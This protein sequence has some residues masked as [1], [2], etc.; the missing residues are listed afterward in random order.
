M[1]KRI[2]SSVINV[3][4]DQEAQILASRPKVRGDMRDP[5][6][7]A[8]AIEYGLIAALIAIAAIAAMQGLGEP[9]FNNAQAG[10]TLSALSDNGAATMLSDETLQALRPKAEAYA[11][12]VNA[13]KATPAAKKAAQGRLQF[14]SHEAYSDA[15]LA[16]TRTPEYNLAEQRGEELY[17]VLESACRGDFFCRR[18]A[19]DDLFQGM[20]TLREAVPIEDIYMNE[21]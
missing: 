14:R 2:W 8:T 1:F 13:A 4:A 5:Q 18:K 9:V 3:L 21:M 17:G 11:R 12:A 10:Q 16:A 20:T 6:C 7:G 15:V 19:E